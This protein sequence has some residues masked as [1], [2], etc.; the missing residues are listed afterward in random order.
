[1][2]DPFN[3]DVDRMVQELCSPGRTWIPSQQVEACLRE[4]GADGHTILTYPD[5]SELC[6]SLG[7]K[8]LK[9][10]NAFKHYLKRLKQDI[11]VIELSDDDDNDNQVLTQK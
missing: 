11:E 3:W 4:Q 9:Y 10:K 6:E 8:T 5:E 1:M 7:I 2:E